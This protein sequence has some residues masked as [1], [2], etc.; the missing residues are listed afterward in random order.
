[1]KHLQG[2]QVHRWN[3]GM[4]PITLHVKLWE[5][6]LQN[7]ALNVRWGVLDGLVHPGQAVVDDGVIKSD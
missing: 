4:L 1:M 3:A 5:N 2:H 6:H 7:R